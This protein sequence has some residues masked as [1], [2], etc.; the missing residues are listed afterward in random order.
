MK[1]KIQEDRSFFK[2]NFDGK[3]NYN[4]KTSNCFFLYMYLYRTAYINVIFLLDNDNP[5]RSQC[6][7]V[8]TL[9]KMSFE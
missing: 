4:V 9:K 1:V 6:H 5:R 2:M 8:L 7:N 3:I